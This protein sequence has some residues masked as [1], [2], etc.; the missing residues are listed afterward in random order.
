MTWFKFS[1]WLAVIYAAYYGALIVAE[2]L[3]ARRI[4]PDEDN[5]ELTFVEETAPAKAVFT[6]ESASAAAISSPVV[7]SGGVSLREIFRL[8]QEE[9]IEYIR[10]VSF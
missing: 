2:L 9:A 4:L 10:P 8:A 6:A 3:R 1:M 7:S 5:I